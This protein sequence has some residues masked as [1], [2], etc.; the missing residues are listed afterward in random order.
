MDWNSWA[1][2]A[3]IA[4][5]VAV[6]ALFRRWNTD[7][8]MKP[9]R[10]VFD[11]GQYERKGIGLGET[12][13]VG[14]YNGRRAVINYDPPS[15]GKE[16]MLSLEL[17]CR[18]PWSFY[19]RVLKK[20]RLMGWM[21]KSGQKLELND[22]ALDARLALHS[23]TPGPALRWFNDPEVKAL[24][25]RWITEEDAVFIAQR[26]SNDLK[27]RALVVQYSYMIPLRTEENMRLLLNR[28]EWLALKAEA[29]G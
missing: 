10:A 21:A 19:V 4:G 15:P 8:K 26:E 29:A 11:G 28:L 27:E 6:A 3:A 24:V 14:R 9:L 5:F 16:G 12:R 25:A 23:D 2:I 1:G 13:Y 7:R 22:P 18:I 20:Q 17:A